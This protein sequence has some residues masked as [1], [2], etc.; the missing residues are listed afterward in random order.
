[1][2]V[3]GILALM[4]LLGASMQQAAP[5][6]SCAL[7]GSP[8]SYALKWLTSSKGITH[9]SNPVKA[10]TDIC[11]GEFMSVGSCCQI[12]QLETYVKNTNTA[13]INKWKA[14]VD[15]LGRAK[16]L[17]PM[18]VKIAAKIT[19]IDV[20]NKWTGVSSNNSLVSK[21]QYTLPLLPTTAVQVQEIKNWVAGFETNLAAFKTQ[22]QT[23]FNSMRKLRANIL[24]AVCSYN[25]YNYTDIQG[26]SEFRYKIPVEQCGTIV[27]T[28]FPIWKFNFYLTSL[29]Q[30]INVLKSKDKGST[31]ASVFNSEFK[32]T[33]DDIMQVRD[34]FAEC[35][36]TNMSLTC[37]GTTPNMT[38]VARLCSKIPIVQHNGYLEGDASFD[39]GLSDSDVE[40]VEP[41]IG[42]NARLLQAAPTAESFIGL[43]PINTS[44]VS[45]YFNKSLSDD[46]IVPADTVDTSKAGDASASS[47]RIFNLAI[48]L[49]AMM[50]LIFTN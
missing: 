35:N 7:T 18:F 8:N 28:C 21:F 40:S 26:A 15:K 24:C 45:G 16:K 42:V 36:V 5:S 48:G 20:L 47:G 12:D 2:K 31:A 27:G 50:S 9:N 17:L 3:F 23:C 29:M 6:G 38:V 37:N 14:F 33:P 4:L 41:K 22:A 46:K 19:S 25:A 34:A 10:T 39:E 11:G 1:M 43:A 30:Y 13:M 49:L 44:V 32:M